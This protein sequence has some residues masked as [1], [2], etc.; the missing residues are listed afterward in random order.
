MGKNTAIIDAHIRQW[1]HN[2]ALAEKIPASHPDWIVTV[3]FYSAVHAIDAALAHDGIFVC[4]H[5]TRFKAIASTNRMK[6]IGLL[7]HPLYN[8]SRTVRYTADPNLWIPA[9][10][11]EK[12]IIRQYLLP[13]ETSVVNLMSRSISLPP[14][15][16]SHLVT[17][18]TPS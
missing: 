12:Q 10:A 1:L 5:E 4:N 14:L 15:N 9:A 16:M 8:L 6:K 13:I 17:A 7:Y 3:A 2:R 11:I 18:S